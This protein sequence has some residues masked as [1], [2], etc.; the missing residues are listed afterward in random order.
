MIIEGSYFATALS[1]H[2][3]Y[4]AV[5]PKQLSPET[6][7]MFLLHGVNAN[8]KTWL[9]N[10]PLPDLANQHNIAFFCPTGE[11]SFYTDHMDGEDYGVAVGEQFYQAMRATFNLRFTYLNTAIAG[12]SMGGYGAVK[13]GLQF[14]YYSQIGGFS[15]AFIFYKRHRDDPVFKHVFVKGLEGSENDAVYLFQ[16]RQTAGG[17]VP[18]THLYCGDADP[19]DAHTRAFKQAV[20]EIAPGTVTYKQQQG[21]HDF[22]LWRPALVDFIQTIWH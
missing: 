15:P 9:V 12:Y 16:Q 8:E 13:L 3:D 18:A 21:F 2:Q 19:L 17:P 1:R 5:L 22:S 6:H 14:P 20:D 10:T 4:V 7:I 11:N